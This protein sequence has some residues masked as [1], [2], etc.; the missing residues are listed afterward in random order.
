MNNFAILSVLL[1]FLLNCLV[2]VTFAFEDLFIA[3]LDDVDNRIGSFALHSLLQSSKEAGIHMMIV[4]NGSLPHSY[5]ASHTS[6]KVRFQNHGRGLD[7]RAAMQFAYETAPLDAVERIIF[8]SPVRHVKLTKNPFAVIR[9]NGEQLT[10][11]IDDSQ[12][13]HKVVA[14]GGVA[15]TVRAVFNCARPHP[16]NNNVNLSDI[17]SCFNAISIRFKQNSLAAK[18][19]GD[20]TTRL[21][22]SPKAFTCQ[23]QQAV[24][25]DN[26][27]E[28][29]VVRDCT[30]PFF[31][32]FSPAASANAVGV[33]NAQHVSK[34]QGGVASNFLQSN[35]FNS[36]EKFTQNSGDAHA[37]AVQNAKKRISERSTWISRVYGSAT[38][39]SETLWFPFTE[40]YACPA[41]LSKS[42]LLAEKL[43][44][45]KW[46]CGLEEIAKKPRCVVYSFGSQG[47]FDFETTVHRTAPQC[48]IHTFDCTYTPKANTVPPLYFAEQ[49]TRVSV[50]VARS[51]NSFLQFFQP[52]P[53]LRL[54]LIYRTCYLV[55]GDTLYKNLSTSTCPHAGA[56]R[57]V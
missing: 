49:A 50:P 39:E 21:F 6:D 28:F 1:L 43:D 9:R 48:E 29:V 11:Y 45:G 47:N 16:T 7:R 57:G 54:A 8:L 12:F 33:N 17:P 41:E 19:S 5:I 34:Q 25:E 23:Q 52:S 53:S 15:K 56:R 55:L 31:P 18:S 32:N 35:T 3:V 24:M 37:V 51:Q 38:T 10:G 42:P 13:S 27:V 20:G 36:V 40:Y 2:V 22:P 26:Q 30:H 46:I 44:G 4:H 14:W